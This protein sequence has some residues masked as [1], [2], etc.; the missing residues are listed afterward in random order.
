MFFA[1][2]A[3][4]A[5]PR[6]CVPP[7]DKYDF[8]NPKLPMSSRVNDLI[9]RLTLDE[10]PTLLI[11]RN[12]PKGN[13]SRLGIPEYDWG[14]NCIHGVQS[15][16]SPDGR[17]PTSFPNPNFLGASFNKTIWRGMGEIIGVELRSLWLQ[18]VGEDHKSN[19]PH[20]G[21]DCWSPNIGVVR[22]P[23]W[24]R[25]LETP[26]EDP[27]V[28]G[29]FGVEVTKGLQES[30]SDPRFV[31]AVVT[32]KHFDANSL[33][34]NWGP[35]GTITRHTC[36]AKISQYD[37]HDTYLP[38]FRQSVVEGK[39]LGVM[40]SY[41]AINGVP[42][43]ANPWLLNQAPPAPAAPPAR[44]ARTAHPRRRAARTA[45]GAHGAPSPARATPRTLRARRCRLPP[46]PR[47]QSL[48]LC[49]ARGTLLATSPRT[50]AP[51]PTSST[52]TTTR[53]TGR[54]R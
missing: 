32:L 47:A 26:S 30:K 49:A 9:S 50:R 5:I 53:A 37:L 31:Q 16:C 28:C 4:A 46:W 45:A 34:G 3:S 1:L 11:A 36:D 35:G 39:A 29:S 12:S 8:C 10:K 27:A 43:C 7:H 40:C 13:V 21:L 18:G 19:L 15:R 38:A 52:T 54:R 24:G 17:C 25:N 6:A 44:A 20:I 51:S 41:N 2:A 42:S 23:R 33:E 22:D 48:R 14:G